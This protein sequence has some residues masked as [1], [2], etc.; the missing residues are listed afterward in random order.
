MSEAVGEKLSR[1]GSNPIIGTGE[2]PDS[3]RT[4]NWAQTP[5]GAIDQW[6]QSLRTVVNILLS[7]RYAMWMGWGSEL[8][9]IFNDAYRPTLGIKAEWALGARADRVWAEIWPDIGPRIDSVL[10][11][12]QAT[13]DEGLLLFLERSG[14]PEE[15]YHTFSYSPLPDDA[16]R[17]NGL[18]CVVTEETERLIG[19]RRVKT[20]RDVASALASTKTESEVLQAVSEQLEQNRK[21]LPFTLIYLF[22]E[23]RRARLASCSGISKEHPLAAEYIESGSAFPWPAQAVFAYPATR[24]IQ[25][26][27]ELHKV[28]ALPSGDWNKPPQQ[29]VV[30]S[31]KQQGQERPAGFLIAGTNP[32]RRYDA[33][34]S[35]FVD[36]LAGQIGAGLANARA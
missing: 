17:I 5:L 29:A 34:Y 8:T 13:Y 22:D 1:I 31:I 27:A 16:G 36:L 35:G 20:L 30:V 32:Y 2:M 14:F 6:P 25:D 12:G 15:T 9:F 23:N 33:A 18:L 24:I 7:S 28:A 4:F 3:V 10:S 19:E 11:T 21:D 26:L